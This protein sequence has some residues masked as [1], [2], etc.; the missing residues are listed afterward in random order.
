MTEHEFRERLTRLETQ[1]EER[2]E[3]LR[4]IGSNVDELVA[5]MHQRKGQS[6]VTATVHRESREDRV[7][8]DTWLRAFLPTGIMTGLWLGVLELLRRLGD[9]LAANGSAAQ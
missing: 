1:S 7:Q 8:R 6:D 9:Y 5:D 3:Q 2:L 4:K